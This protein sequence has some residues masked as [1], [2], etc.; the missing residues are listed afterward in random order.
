[1]QQRNATTTTVT[2]WH[3]SGS[4]NPGNRNRGNQKNRGN[5]NVTANATV[6]ANASVN[7]SVTANAK[8]KQPRVVVAVWFVVWIAAAVAGVVSFSLNLVIAVATIERH[9][10]VDVDVAAT[11]RK[12]RNNP[13]QHHNDNDIHN[14]NDND[15]H[16]DNKNEEDGSKD[17]TADATGSGTSSSSWNDYDKSLSLLA[18]NATSTEVVLE[19]GDVLYLPTYWF[20]FIVGLDVNMQ[21]NTRSGRDGRDD[22]VM[23][24]CGFPPKKT[25]RNRRQRKR[26]G[27]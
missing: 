4:L 22:K 5:A 21:C 8:Q 13:L 9:V 20:H 27:S 7:A 24:D 16:N 10:D 3:H 19:A 26:S 12:P 14:D 23:T 1:M 11:E 18:N 6:N 25:G 15:I 17:A 2:R